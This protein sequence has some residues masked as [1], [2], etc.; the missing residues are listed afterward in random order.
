MYDNVGTNMNAP[1]LSYRLTA[2]QKIKSAAD[3]KLTY[4]RKKSSADSRL[5]VYTCENGLPFSRLGV[6]V[7]R[8]NGN[9]VVRNRIKRM[10]R[11]AF[12]LSQHNLPVG[13]DFVLVPKAGALIHSLDDWKSSLVDLGNRAAKKLRLAEPLP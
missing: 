7:S 1:T 12:R 9:A 11:E 3:F 10:F 2:K 13:V 4:D 8:K 6:S 5:I